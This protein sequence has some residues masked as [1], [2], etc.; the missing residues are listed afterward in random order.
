MVQRAS[1]QFLNFKFW[2]KQR[3]FEFHNVMCFFW[4]GQ[5]KSC[6]PYMKLENKTIGHFIEF[7]LVFFSYHSKIFFLLL[8]IISTNIYHVKFRNLMII[9]KTELHS[10]SFIYII[11]KY[12]TTI[13][14]TI[15]NTEESSDDFQTPCT[16]C[17]LIRYCIIFFLLSFNQLF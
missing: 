8:K 10:E 2:A 5:V 15:S 4:S 3:K 16:Y 12:L 1:I 11:L 7:P 17:N 13:L 14:I 6:I 9:K